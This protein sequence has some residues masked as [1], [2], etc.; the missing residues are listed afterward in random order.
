ML[1]TPAK[2]RMRKTWRFPKDSAKQLNLPQTGAVRRGEWGGASLLRVSALPGPGPI[3]MITA[4][5]VGTSYPV[6]GPRPP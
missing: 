2:K 6:T 4:T 1:G 3:T 5:G